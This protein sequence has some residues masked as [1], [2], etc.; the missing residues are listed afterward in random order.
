MPDYVPQT[1]ANTSGGGTPLSAA[2][3]NAMEQGIDRAYPLRV[4]SLPGSPFDGQMI[5]YVADATNGVVWP[6]VYVSASAST[7][8]WEAIG[9]TPLTA[10]VLTLETTLSSSFADLATVGPS[11]TVPLAGDYLIELAANFRT[12]ATGTALV[13][14]KLGAA[15]TSADDGLAN[16]FANSFVPGSRT[17]RRNGLAANA[18]LKLQYQTSGTGTGSFQRRNLA[19]WPIRV[20]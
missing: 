18:V 13:A 11:V 17:I 6:L 16:T 20:S 4:T 1:W 15:A 3:L 10:Q 8:K 19:V 7:H 14:V 9:P 2:R 5:H 12:D